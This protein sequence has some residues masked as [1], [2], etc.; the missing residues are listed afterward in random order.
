MFTFKKYRVVAYNNRMYKDW[1]FVGNDVKTLSGAKYWIAQSGDRTRYL[2]NI[3]NIETETLV[4]DY[5]KLFKD[6]E[7]VRSIIK[8]FPYLFRSPYEFNI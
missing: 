1:R 4:Y 3:Y 8:N 6:Y 2:Y 5:S 7:R